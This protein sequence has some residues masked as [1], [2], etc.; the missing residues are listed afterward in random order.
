LEYNCAVYIGNVVKYA[1]NVGFYLWT[2]FNFNETHATVAGN[3]QSLVVAESW[4]LHAGRR[5]RLHTT[6]H[7]CR[8]YLSI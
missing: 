1:E 2:L 6:Q 8:G 3:G 7:T 4:N 5:T